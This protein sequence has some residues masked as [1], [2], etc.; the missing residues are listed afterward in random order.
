MFN[1]ALIK[2]LAKENNI[3]VND[4]LVLA[5]QNDPFYTGSKAQIR[6]AEWI[7]GLYF[8]VLGAPRDVHIRRIHYSLV[9]RGDILKPN[10]AVYENT[11]RDWNYLENACKYAR[12]LDLIPADDFVDR[13]NPDPE[14][15][16][17]YW[18]NED[19]PL[20]KLDVYGVLDKI[21]YSIMPYNPQLS[22]A[23]HLEIWC[24][25]STMND[26]LMPLGNQF[27]ANIV[28]GMGELSITAVDDCVK[29]VVTAERPARIFYISDFDPAGVNMPVSVARKLEYYSRK[30]DDIPNIRLKHLVLTKDQ[31]VE[32]RLP[33][34]PIKDTDKRK[35]GF[36]ERHGEGATEL[37][38]LEALRPGELRK[39]ITE[40]LTPYF[41][42]ASYGKVVSENWNIRAALRS[43]LKTEIEQILDNLDLDLDDFDFPIS[44]PLKSE[45]DDFLL[46][47]SRDYVDQLVEYKAH[48]SPGIDAK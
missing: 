27:N 17:K 31:C 19:H 32:Y 47:T 16:A 2:R 7:A 20:D 3:K 11:Q 24:E 22:Q 13:R 23:Y 44:K 26:I 18:Q 5:P 30:Y 39:L 48:K 6:D 15:N 10:G 42:K 9:S 29:R 40:V 12:Y 35:D 43:K 1:Y 8:D 41:D 21:A 37:D 46:D 25:K 36:E 45:S 34:T 4:L 14:I 33:R 28:T 38:A